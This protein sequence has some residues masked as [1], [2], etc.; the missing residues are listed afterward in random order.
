MDELARTILFLFASLGFIRANEDR[1][2]ADLGIVTALIIMALAHRH[3]VPPIRPFCL[4]HV[5]TDLGGS[6]AVIDTA[7][8]GPFSPALLNPMLFPTTT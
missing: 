4:L 5:S 2:N 7:F 6:A 3:D 8:I 1:V